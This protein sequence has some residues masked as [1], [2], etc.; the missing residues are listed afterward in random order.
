MRTFRC[1]VVLFAAMAIA[2]AASAQI[3]GP[4]YGGGR[5]SQ[6]GR[7]NDSIGVP[8]SSVLAV[9]RRISE[10]TSQIRQAEIQLSKLSQ[11]IQNRNQRVKAGLEPPGGAPNAPNFEAMAAQITEQMSQLQ[12][13]L[14]AA[15]RLR[16]L[17]SPVDVTL[18]SSTIR[19]AAEALS[20]ASKLS[21]AVDPKVP[22]DVK[23]N[24]EAQNVPLGAVLEVIANAAA[25]IISPTADGGLLLRVPGT[26]VVD[27]ATYITD[28][29][30]APWS[31][32][33]G[34]STG[35][36]GSIIGRK[37][38]GL[39]APYNPYAFVGTSPSPPGIAPT[40]PPSAPGPPTAPAP[41]AP[42]KSA[43]GKPSHPKGK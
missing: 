39:F 28:G 10:L 36:T 24:A 38:L 20:R 1:L 17:A 41:K 8:K 12:Q 43:G 33:W 6:T 30:T 26:L 35:V 21:I 5:P 9:D 14:T 32:D 2:S 22:Q 31:D 40:S 42:P 4:G 25:L 27:G 23:V 19:Q 18:K 37:W 11:E 3:P 34:V 29:D 7:A 16:S 13:E 15:N